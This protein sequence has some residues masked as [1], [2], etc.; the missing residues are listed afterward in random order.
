MSHKFSAID[1]GFRSSAPPERSVYCYCSR[2]NVSWVGCDDERLCEYCGYDAMRYLD[3]PD[4]PEGKT[5]R[6]QKIKSNNL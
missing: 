1:Q 4:N 5:R 3:H 6:E 2:C